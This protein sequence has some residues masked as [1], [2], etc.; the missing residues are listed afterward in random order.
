VVFCSKK[1]H[2]ADYVF[3]TLSPSTHQSKISL[4]DR[5]EYRRIIHI[6]GDSIASG[7]VFGEFEDPNPLNRIQDI[8]N[9][10]LAE[11]GYAPK[12]LWVRYA[13]SQDIK[14]MRTELASGL[15]VDWDIILYEDAG[16][17]ENNVV[18]RRQ[19]YLDIKRIIEESGRKVSLIL[20]TMFDY[21]PH[22]PGYYN[23]EYD[24]LI[25]NSGLT[26][27]DVARSVASDSAC[28]LLDWNSKMD[29]AME[30]LPQRFRFSPMF[31]DGIH[32]NIFGN[33][34]LASSLL[35]HMGIPIT[36]CNSIRDAFHKVPPEY[37][38]RPGFKKP[39]DSKQLNE[40]INVIMN[41]FTAAQS[42]RDSSIMS[43]QGKSTGSELLF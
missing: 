35:N 27:N 4:N 34:L 43:R 24:A 23:S 22:P 2:I 10:L 7:Y 38:K 31:I 6:Y 16:P 26:M 40:I 36:H 25:E 28:S 8:A 18:A 3:A 39:F 17:H 1:Y 14:Q 37:Y 20:T 5:C 9:M 32:P 11:N 41:L 13:G 19:R 42:N 15:I 33:L 29:L 21:K 30:I 12:K